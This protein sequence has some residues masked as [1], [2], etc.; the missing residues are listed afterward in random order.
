MPINRF[1]SI[2]A[3][4]LLRRWHKPGNWENVSRDLHQQHSW[5]MQTMKFLSW[6]QVLTVYVLEY[7]ITAEFYQSWKNGRG[8]MV[9]KICVA[10]G[11][12]DVNLMLCAYN[13]GHYKGHGGKVQHVLQAQ[14]HMPNLKP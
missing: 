8:R 3:F 12:G 2:K 10:A 14:L 9:R 1:H 7:W 5:C 13:N 4:V 6:L 11:C